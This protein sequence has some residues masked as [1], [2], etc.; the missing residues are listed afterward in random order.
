M[1]SRSGGMYASICHMKRTTIFIDEGTERELHAL[2]KRKKRPMASIVREAV[3]R[4]V[5]EN[6]EVKASRLGFIAAGR[7]GHADTAER[8]EDRL[9][10]EPPSPVPARKPSRHKLSRRRKPASGRAP[11]TRRRSG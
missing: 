5:V 1:P 8:H 2:S 10:D 7:S 3:E 6:R 11:R 9:F 4:Y